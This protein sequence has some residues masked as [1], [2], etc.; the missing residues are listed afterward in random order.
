MHELTGIDTDG[1]DAQLAVFLE[2]TRSGHRRKFDLG[3][4]NGTKSDLNKEV[5]TRMTSEHV[6]KI[7]DEMKQTLT[8]AKE[9]AFT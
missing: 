2:Q 3:T 1:M 6:D 7:S 4:F 8:A 9:L 5:L